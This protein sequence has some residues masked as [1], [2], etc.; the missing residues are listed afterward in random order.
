M[1]GEEEGAGGRIRIVWERAKLVCI[2]KA[3]IIALNLINPLAR[4]AGRG[5]EGGMDGGR[6][7]RGNDGG[8]RQWE[9]ASESSC[10]HVESVSEPQL[11]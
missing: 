7:A 10:V 2:Y 5:L 3:V 4:A 11:A 9:F 8:I 6:S 1:N